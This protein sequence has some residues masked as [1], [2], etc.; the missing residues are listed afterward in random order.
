[1]APS[2]PI[3]CPSPDRRSFPRISG[4]DVP[5]INACTSRSATAD[6]ID[7]S[8]GGV[9]IESRACLKPGDREIVLLEG[10]GR[11]RVVGWAERVEIT[12]LIPSVSYRTAIRFAEPIALR[13][14]A[15]DPE[16]GGQPAE[17]HKST[18]LTGATR[19]LVERFTLWVRALSGIHAVRVAA[20]LAQHP[21]TEP[22]HFAVPTSQFGEGRLLQVFFASGAVPSAGEFAHLR[23]LAEV[24][25]ALPDLDIAK[26]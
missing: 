16:P 25:T 8:D 6:V 2:R 13:M 19:E 7:I 18:L 17:P 26:R 9:L 20:T 5:L 21:G 15:H 10:A 14:L 4:A 23:H 24:A 3:D 1:M 11:I 12:R 22:I